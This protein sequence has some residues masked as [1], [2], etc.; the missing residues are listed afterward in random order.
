[1]NRYYECE[2]CTKDKKCSELHYY[3]DL[4]KENYPIL[5]QSVLFNFDKN[6]YNEKKD[7]LD[8]LI[9]DI[10]KLFNKKTPNPLIWKES[11]DD[12]K[13]C[14]YVSLLELLNYSMKNESFKY[15]N[16]DKIENDLKEI[17]NFLRNKK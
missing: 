2:K 12:M 4:L 6:N 5:F 15:L 17:P 1:M 3:L 16:I 7:I 11:Y 14:E 8:E 10:E 13:Y 9:N